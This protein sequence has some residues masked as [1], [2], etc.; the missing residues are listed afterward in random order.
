VD[1]LVPLVSFVFVTAITPGPNNL[2]LVAA[3]VR[4]GPAA[5]LPHVG[6]I[7]LGVSV[8]VLLCGLGLDRML[9]HVPAL[10]V[11][12]KVAASG[13]LLYLA[14][15]LFAPGT[16]GAGPDMARPL[17]VAQATTFQFANPK[18][19]MMATSAIGLVA[20]I[21]SSPLVAAALL[22][23]SFA[24]I[25]VACNAIWILGGAA[26]RR[27]LDDPRTRRLVNGSLAAL[28]I[29]TVALFWTT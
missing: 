14:W 28:T 23:A 27:H 25:G 16:S 17:T 10:M 8:M 3:S 29:A 6:G 19:W 26:I 5:T 13:Y 11:V 20:P 22:A 4:F 1:A 9:V 2:L 7:V 24:T 12:L 21:T 18:A 15:R